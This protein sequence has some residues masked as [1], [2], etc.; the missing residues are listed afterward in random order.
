MSMVACESLKYR[1]SPVFRDGIRSGSGLYSA[2]PIQ[3]TRDNFAEG[4]SHWFVIQN[5]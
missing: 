1:K 3:I 5:S 4:I 2:A